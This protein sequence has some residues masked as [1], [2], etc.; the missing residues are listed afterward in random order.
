[1]FLLLRLKRWQPPSRAGMALQ[2]TGPSRGPI[3]S[4]YQG[5]VT[6]FGGRRDITHGWTAVG[7][8][9]WCWRCALIDMRSFDPQ[10][11]PVPR[12]SLLPSI[13]EAVIYLLLR[14]SC[15]G[16]RLRRC[17]G[18]TAP[19]WCWGRGWIGHLVSV[20]RKGVPGRRR[21]WRRGGVS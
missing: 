8:V 5:Q 6:R 19:A 9:G 15:P 10:P 21:W 3:Q 2:A 17:G 16:R 12:E 1:M 7:G 14:C 4:Q 18:P 11:I 13:Y 20:Q